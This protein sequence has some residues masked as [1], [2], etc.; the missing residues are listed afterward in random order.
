MNDEYEFDFEPIEEPKKEILTGY[1][2]LPCFKCEIRG[3]VVVFVCKKFLFKVFHYIFAPFWT[4]RVH[5][6]G[7]K[8]E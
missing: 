2:M 7:S 6:T 4:G 5:I 1:V 3:E 8:F